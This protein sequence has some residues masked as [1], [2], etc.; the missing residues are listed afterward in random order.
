MKN[1]LFTALG[2]MTGTSM[3]GVDISL[4]K[5]DG[6]EEFTHILDRYFEFDHQLSKKL[7]NLRKKLLNYQDLRK[8]L[9]RD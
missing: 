3:D 1:K 9:K 8:N 6:D 4:I 5:S 7:I 2:V